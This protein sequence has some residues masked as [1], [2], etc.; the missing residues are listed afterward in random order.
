MQ[1]RTFV[2]VVS[3]PRYVGPDESV[4]EVRWLDMKM[5]RDCTGTRNQQTCVHRRVV[6]YDQLHITFQTCSADLLCNR[7]GH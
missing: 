5:C 7:L 2:V 3:A 4:L 1:L 6:G